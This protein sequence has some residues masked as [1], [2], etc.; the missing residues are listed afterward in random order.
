VLIE[1][2]N[3]KYSQKESPLTNAKLNQ[4]ES[5]ELVKR[6]CDDYRIKKK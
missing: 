4:E 1:N 2:L 5:K 6:L 3:E